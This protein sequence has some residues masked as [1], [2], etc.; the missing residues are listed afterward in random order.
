[1]HAPSEHT[2]SPS[3]VSALPERGIDARVKLVFLVAYAISLFLVSSWAGMIVAGLAFAFVLLSSDVR[4]GGIFAFSTPVYVLLAFMIVASSVV[5]G[6][7]G[8]LPGLVP[9]AGVFHFS[10]EGFAR[11]CFYATRILLLVWMSLTLCLS[12][13]AAEATCALR[14][15]ASPLEKLGVDT[16]DLLMVLSIAVRFIP[17]MAEQFVRVR[18]AQWS[19][20]G[21][22]QEGLLR[23][24]RA[25]GSVLVPVLAG[26]FDRADALGEAMESRCFGAPGKRTSLAKTSMSTPSKAALALG[27]ALCVLLAVAF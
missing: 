3:R 14:S 24:I 23:Q 18:A 9:L 12:I 22:A 8:S 26:L 5:V 19:R 25:W 10:P 1:M 6:Q 2:L 17:L 4:R 15:F 21:F 27:L 11:S 7:E 20:G 13:S 16:T